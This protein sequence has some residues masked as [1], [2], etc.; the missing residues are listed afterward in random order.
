MRVRQSVFFKI[1]L[2][3]IISVIA[4]NFSVGWLF[5]HFIVKSRGDTVAM[6]IDNYTGLLVREIGTPP[7]MGKV[8]EI[9]RRTRMTI[10][11]DTSLQSLS[12]RYD[13]FNADRRFGSTWLARSKRKLIAIHE[14]D[15]R[16]TAF[17]F[18]DPG[19]SPDIDRGMVFLFA[20][21]TVI[22]ILM[23]F[24]I[25]RILRPVREMSQ[26]MREIA[27]GNLNHRVAVT[28]SDELGMLAHSFNEMNARIQQTLAAKERLLYDISHE[29]RTPAT[30][31][32]L[33][34]EL[35][36]ESAMKQSIIDD[37][38]EMESMTASILRAGSLS[39]GSPQLRRSPFP[40]CALLTEI[41]ARYKDHAPR[42]SVDSGDTP[43]YA[44][45][46]LLGLAI[47]N[48]VDNAVKHSGGSDITIRGESTDTRV[49]I[50]IT[51]NGVGIPDD[52]TDRIFDPFY[53]VDESRTRVTGGF[54]L[55]LSISRSIVT[56]HGGGIDL[57]SRH[58]QT[59]F[60]ISIPAE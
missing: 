27:A 35:L 45:R 40:L 33:A 60:T 14:H 18:R 31:I 54:G 49:I 58:G 38:N 19:R 59:C 48:I 23:Y 51:D 16:M 21:I 26:G 8:R 39:G 53:R 28:S 41:A 2:I 17:M 57:Q 12:E 34:A 3:I 55:G 22:T 20:T 50:R 47:R 4:I 30:R 9:E 25:K 52:E 36:D 37:L 42:I 5:H 24:V 6:N 56:A 32:R 13:S 7:D 11:P 15:G 43:V 44:D 10:I 1:T 46:E 29:L